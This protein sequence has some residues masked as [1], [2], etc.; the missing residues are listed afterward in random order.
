M[1]KT[2]QVMTA[3]IIS[4][5][6]ILGLIPVVSAQEDISGALSATSIPSNS[7]YEHVFKISNSASVSVSFQYANTKGSESGSATVPAS[8]S[9]EV[10][11]SGKDAQLMITYDGSSSPLFV[12]SSRRYWV[13][14]KYVDGNGNT[15]SSDKKA[16]SYSEG[17]IS[18]TA[19]SKLEASGKKYILNDNA[20]K[21]HVYGNGDAT[22]TFEYKED[23]PE[24]YNIQIVCLDGAKGTVLKTSALS[25]Q[26]GSSVTVKPASALTVNGKEYTLDQGQATSTHQY[27]DSTREYRF[28]YTA[29]PAYPDKPYNIAI[30]YV[31][32][33]SGQ[34]IARFNR[35]V[36]VGGIVEFDT[37]TKYTTYDY[38]EYHRVAGQPEQ[39]VH[40][41]NN[42]TRTYTIQYALDATVPSDPYRIT[43][44]YVDAATGKT[45][46]SEEKTVAVNGTVQHTAPAYFTEG[47]A[48]YTISSGQTRSFRHSFGD[49]RRTYTVYYNAPGADAQPYEII[50]K[51]A[52]N[53][54]N[55]ILWSQN[56]RVEVG[57][58]VYHQ[59]LDTYRVDGTNYAL[60]TGQSAQMVHTYSNARREY[61][62]LYRD[63][64]IVAPEP[65]NPDNDNEPDVIVDNEDVINQLPVVEVPEEPI[66]LAPGGQEN[67]PTSSPS[68]SPEEK[69]IE[70]IEDSPPSSFGKRAKQDRMVLGGR[71]RSACGTDRSWNNSDRQE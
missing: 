33:A 2:I 44:L 50:I 4:L 67:D 46:Q 12:Q 35:T 40:V 18:V 45:L 70:T 1:K 8:S 65:S 17:S 13:S 60:C 6:M 58:A 49:S 71:R 43:F 68:T 57:Q 23:V 22:I 62:F 38:K 51:Y 9:I 32:S 31:D 27:G 15:L 37:A 29:A 59:P 11:C 39:I 48:T 28:T 25:V 63:T 21:G 52:D 24:P 34:T 36:P 10:K 53:I 41:A 16:V 54:T 69:P 14:I 56:V 66:P 61:T 42:A 7:A 20:T 3:I 5:T 19:P 26:V 47:G 64:G 55:E 30:K